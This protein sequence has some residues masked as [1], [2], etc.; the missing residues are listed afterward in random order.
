[1]TQLEEQFK[2]GI[3]ENSEF[4]LL[5]Q[6][7]E[8]FENGTTPHEKQNLADENK[9]PTPSTP[10]PAT[11]TNSNNRNSNN[12]HA[13]N[14]TASKILRDYYENDDEYIVEVDGDLDLDK[15]E[16]Q[17]ENEDFY[18]DDHDDD[19]D[20][21][22]GQNRFASTNTVVNLGDKELDE[23]NYFSNLNKAR[24]DSYFSEGDG[25]N[26]HTDNLNNSNSSNSVE[27][28]MLEKFKWV[29][30]FFLLALNLKFFNFCLIYLESF[31]RTNT[32]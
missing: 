19:D 12:A 21:E 6:L 2:E 32:T 11:N 4:K 23:N 10:S 20:V 22:Y 27:V 28:Q 31:I 7:I 30:A 25:N 3:F 8:I 26:E 14:S 15:Q 5:K 13:I 17:D 9:K 1:M 18:N 16:S 24:L 29:Y